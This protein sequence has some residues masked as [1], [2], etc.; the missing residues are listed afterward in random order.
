MPHFS[1][2]D[3]HKLLQKIAVLETK[4]N[5][6]EANVDRNGRC[7]NETTSCDQNH[8][9][10]LITIDQE[11]YGSSN[12]SS[13][14]SLG[15]KP[16]SSHWNMG[17]QVTS[18]AQHPEIC[19]ETGWPKLSSTPVQRKKQPWIAAKGGP[20]IKNNL[21]PQQPSLSLHNR[22]APLLRNPGSSSPHSRVRS[23]RKSKNGEPQTLIVGDSAIKDIQN[24]SKNSK[25]LCFP[26]DMVCDI[27][28][29]IQDIVASY[30]SLTAIVIHCGANDIVTEQSEKLK[31][32]FSELLKTVSSLNAQVFISGPLPPIKRG[33]M[34]FSRLFAL[35]RWLSTACTK[36][37]F[38]DNFRLFWDRRHYFRADGLSLNKA[39]VKLF[40]S[41]LYHSLRHPSVKDKRQ[42]AK[43]HEIKHHGLDR[44]TPRAPPRTKSFGS[45]QK[46]ESVLLLPPLFLED[47]PCSSKEEESLLPVCPPTEEDVPCQTSP[48]ASSS[49]GTPSPSSSLLDFPAELRELENAGVRL[50]GTPLHHSSHRTV[51][52]LQTP[53]IAPNPPNSNVPLLLPHDKEYCSILSLS[54]IRAQD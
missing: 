35:N 39:G 26:K 21:P 53:Q 41:N 34:R 52:P 20:K 36:V 51:F 12:A 50:S 30:P 32:D 37:N 23:E 29:K 22:F 8:N 28:G 3:Y 2:D 49:L 10:Q 43:R 4:I 44:E 1:T 45:S 18:R 13:S 6:L 54:V 11:D 25:V 14:D 5:R 40:T 33:D 27:T 19:D 7:G 42:E 47:P 46:E 31:R 48:I 9:T 15:A 38:I 16:K 17:G 24:M